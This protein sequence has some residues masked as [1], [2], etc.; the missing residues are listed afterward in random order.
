M[1]MIRIFSLAFL[2]L[3]LLASCKKALEQP[4]DE[5]S[6]VAVIQASPVVVSTPT[7]PTDTL[8]VFVDDM[9]YNGSNVLYNT[10]T[11]YL[12]VAA[13]SKN[14]S[15]KRGLTTSSSNYVNPFSYTF[16]KAKAY[17]FFVYDTTTSTTAQAKVLRLKDDLTLPAAGMSHFRFLHL[18]P[19]G[20][21]VDVTIT[22]TAT[23]PTG[24]PLLA[25]YDSVT[26]ATNR[27][28]IGGSP[29]ED[30]LAAFTPASRGTVYVARIKAAGTGNV[31]ASATI[32]LTQANTVGSDVGEGRIVTIYATGT[33]KGRP[34]AI[35]TFRH[36]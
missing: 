17:S 27:S 34:L 28:Y 2:S 31:L 14:I 3:A 26:I 22:R 33:A 20:V 11:G 35:G 15:I 4:K 30:A 8:Q 18:A 16:E 5:W 24:S 1:I 21:P 25:T 10:N 12:P 32:N 9:K 23:A 6:S 19:N 7:T 36:Y 29:N 13:G